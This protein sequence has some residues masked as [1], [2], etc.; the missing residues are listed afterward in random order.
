MAKWKE[1]SLKMEQG[2]FLLGLAFDFRMPEKL[3]QKAFTGIERV[4]GERDVLALYDAIKRVSPMIQK[5]GREFGKMFGPKENWDFK[6]DESGTIVSG[7]V[8]N[9]EAEVSIQLDESAVSGAMWCLLLVSHPESATARSVPSLM[10]DIVF[11]IAIRLRRLTALQEEL[12]ITSAQSKAWQEDA[13]EP[14]K[15]I[16]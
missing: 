11:P 10:S 16:S 1:Y 4:A 2:Q 7:D 8:K 9:T 13:V 14:E 6:R 12:G 5:R 15:A 3:G